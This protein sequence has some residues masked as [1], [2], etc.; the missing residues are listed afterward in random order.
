MNGEEFMYA[1]MHIRLNIFKY[2]KAMYIL[3]VIFMF[4]FVFFFAIARLHKIDR[5]SNLAI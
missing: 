4:F 5:H 3:F 2:T 1:C